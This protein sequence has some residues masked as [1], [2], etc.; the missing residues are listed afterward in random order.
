MIMAV[1]NSLLMHPRC[2]RGRR[3]EFY[4]DGK[5]KN[6]SIYKSNQTTITMLNEI[7]QYISLKEKEAQEIKKDMKIYI[8]INR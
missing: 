6:I 7:N 8:E 3:G 4:I 1:E 2:K 5:F